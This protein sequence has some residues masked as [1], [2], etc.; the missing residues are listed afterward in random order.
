MYRYSV[1]MANLVEGRELEVLR[2][3]CS[4]VLHGAEKVVNSTIWRMGK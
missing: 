1:V 4:F 3:W 2:R